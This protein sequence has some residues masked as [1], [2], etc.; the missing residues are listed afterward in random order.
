MERRFCFF[1][2]LPSTESPGFHHLEGQNYL[3]KDDPHVGQKGLAFGL[4]CS[5]L[6][7][8]F[9]GLKGK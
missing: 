5:C 4:Y 2:T 9:I 1:L 7:G 6:I 8:F 3:G